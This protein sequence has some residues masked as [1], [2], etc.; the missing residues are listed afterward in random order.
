MRNARPA[1]P[2]D[3]IGATPL[4][5]IVERE[6][7]L[8]ARADRLSVRIER[9]ACQ[10]VE[11][12]DKVGDLATTREVL[13]SLELDEPGGGGGPTNPPGNPVHERIL[14]ALAAVGRPVRAK[15]LCRELEVGV[16]RNK[17]E[18]MRSLLGRLVA[19]GLIT[20]AEPGLFAIRHGSRAR[21]TPPDAA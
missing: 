4:D 13:L 10:V 12:E 16:E 1:G 18:G 19:H 15:A 11:L 9:L 2:A 5:K 21:R 20:E 7:A 3:A 14:A 8:R 17:I 6:R